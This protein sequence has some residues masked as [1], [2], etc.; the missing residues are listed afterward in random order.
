MYINQNME[1]II[2]NIGMQVILPVHNRTFFDIKLADFI[3]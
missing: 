1:F 2:D 3:P